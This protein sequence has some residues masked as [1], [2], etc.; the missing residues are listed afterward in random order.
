MRNSKNLV[1]CFFFIISVL[2][3]ERLIYAAEQIANGSFSPSS[4]Y[5]KNYYEDV[6]ELVKSVT[7]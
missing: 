1:L 6:Y 2:F 5:C 7:R 3:F 4:P